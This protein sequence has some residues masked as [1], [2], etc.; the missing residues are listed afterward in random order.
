[1]SLFKRGN[2]W[3]YEFQFK[4]TRIQESSL[5]TNKDSARDVESKRR[6]DL[7]AATTGIVRGKPLSFAKAAKTWLEG[8]AHWSDSTREVMELKL[9][10]LQGDFGKKLLLEIDNDDI[11]RFQTKRKKAKASGRE[12][13]MEL[14]VLRM[15][16]RKHNRGHLLAPQYKPMPEREK[17]GK[18]LTEDEVSRL[19]A[20]AKKSRSQS[21]YPALVLLLN[22]GLRSS[23]LRTMQWRQVD[24]IE[25]MLTVG[26]SK[27]EGG[28]GRMVPLNDE[29]L[30]ALTEWRRCFDNPLPD[31]YLFP[32][33][34]YGF[35]GEQ[36]HLNG[37]IMVYDRNPEK[38]IGSWKVAWNACRNAAGVKCR[39]HDARHTFCSRLGEAKVSEA[40][41]VALA[42]WMSRKM[43]ERYSHSRIEAKREA[44]KSASSTGSLQKSLQSRSRG[45]GEGE[46]TH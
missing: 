45:E 19:L 2:I 29:A 8:N 35:A 39:L 1:M 42:G 20:A 17:P 31:H 18:A 36:G 7:K 14:A 41:M 13:N 12:I 37:A 44:V 34:K 43:L 30:S 4:G 6:L 23:E 10:H 27:T 21:L 38:P 24:W 46:I 25:H 11:S 15:V 16:L 40:T 28:E 32:S 5:M 3:W 9:R 22:T 33:E 26:A